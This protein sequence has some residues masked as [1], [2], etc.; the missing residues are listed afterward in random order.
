MVTDGFGIITHIV[1]NFGSDIRLF[2]CYKVVVIA[3]GLALQN[4]AVVKQDNIFP[5]LL[6]QLIYIVTDACHRTFP[7][8]IWCKKVIIL[9]R[10]IVQRRYFVGKETAMHIAGLKNTEI[11]NFLLCCYWQGNA[12]R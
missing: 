12:D 3:C 7:C 1:D 9:L 8:S 6:A 4:V 11:D 2:R 5:H 10:C